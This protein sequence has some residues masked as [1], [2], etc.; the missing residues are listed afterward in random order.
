MKKKLL[1]FFLYF[2]VNM[3][4]VV[5]AENTHF[6]TYEGFSNFLEGHAQNTQ[7]MADG[8]VALSMPVKKISGLESTARLIVSAVDDSRIALVLLEQKPHLWV[9]HHNGSKDDYGFIEQGV[10]TALALGKNAIYVATV[11][12]AQILKFQL[13]KKTLPIPMPTVS[14]SKQPVD[15]VF[16]MIEKEDALYLLTSMPGA[17][18]KFKDGQFQEL[19]ISNEDL[20]KSMA[21][22]KT[23]KNIYVGGGAKGIVYK[24]PNQAS[25]T[26]TRAYQAIFDSGLKEITGLLPK[27]TGDLFVVGLSTQ[28]TNEDNS[29]SSQSLE[30]G[31]IRSQ[32]IYLN[33]QGYGEVL[34]GSDDE[35]IYSISETPQKNV[36]IATGSVDKAHLRGRLYEARPKTK[37]ISLLYQ[38]ESAQIVQIYQHQNASMGY[39]L[40]E[41]DP[42]NI[43]NLQLGYATQGEFILPVFDAFSQAHFGSVWLDA[44]TPKNTQIQIQ[45]RVG[46]TAHP[47]DNWSDWTQDLQT[48]V[49]AK[50]L[51]VARF[52]QIKIKLKGD[53]KQTPIARR[54]RLAYTRQNIAPIIEDIVILPKHIMLNTAVSDNVYERTFSLNDKG[55]ME[56]KKLDMLGELSEPSKV[57]QTYVNNM[58]SIA[59][60]AQDFNHD[61]LVYDVE[62]KKRTDVSFQLFQS[63]LKDSFVSFP[64]HTFSDGVYMFRITAK[65]YLSNALEQ[66]LESKKE[67]QW[68][69]FDHTPPQIQNIK[70]NSQ[71]GLSFEIK[72]AWSVLTQVEFSI[73]GQPFLL[74]LPRDH[75]LDSTQESF[76]LTKEDLANYQRIYPLSSHSHTHIINIRATDEA[77]NIAHEKFNF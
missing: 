49:S 22:D 16:Y 34:A 2:Y 73:D 39:T 57:K 15:A 64:S 45:L 23:G 62:F 30:K 27:E 47:D 48:G 56:L 40:V 52:A 13:S 43:V 59:W 75:V 68:V 61:K 35:I 71:T 54:I 66:S 38:T 7:L 12:P 69:T 77:K 19:F 60:S 32:L 31:K 6:Y 42:A 36:L 72:D 18:L 44:E 1:Y 5:Y 10:P 76:V 55:L 53:G 29:A 24:G 17:L 41:N 14:N 28:N 46:Q 58:Q 3:V 63:N 4:S 37:D 11:A 50:E 21:F 65:D 9:Y 20:L 25:K 8:V 26:P 74:I 51:M 70:G 67:S 33:A